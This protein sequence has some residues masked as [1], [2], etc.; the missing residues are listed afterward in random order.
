MRR[1]SSASTV[2]VRIWTSWGVLS[3]RVEKMTGFNDT[4]KIWLYSAIGC[5]RASA[6]MNSH[7]FPST[8]LGRTGMSSS[9]GKVS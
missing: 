7:R 8:N 3:T 6:N 1:T 9:D 5:N 2:Q 4:K